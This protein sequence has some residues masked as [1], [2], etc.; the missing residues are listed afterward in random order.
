MKKIKGSIILFLILIIC[1]IPGIVVAD[2]KDYFDEDYWEWHTRTTTSDLAYTGKHIEI[3]DNKIEFFGY[4]TTSYKDFL[5]KE[6]D[7]AGSKTFK[8]QLELDETKADYHTLDGAGFI[9]N[10]KKN[11]GKLTGDIL[12]VN[13]EEIV[14]YRIE[15]IDIEEFETTPNKILADYKKDSNSTNILESVAK[16]ETSIHKFTIKTTPEN[17]TVIDNEK[18]VLNYNLDYSKHVGNDFGLIVSYKQHS[19][20]KLTKIEFSEFELEIKDYNIMIKNTDKKE[21]PIEKSKFQILDS[22]GNVLKTMT[23][24]DNGEI[25]L[26]GVSSGDYILKQVDVNDE[27][28]LNKEEIKFSVTSDGKVLDPKTKEEIDLHVIN[29]KNE[30]IDNNKNDKV[31]NNYK[32]NIK[33]EEQNKNKDEKENLP[34]KLPDAG[35]KIIIGLIILCILS[36]L[37]QYKGYNMRI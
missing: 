9:F 12:V 20:G 34:N 18:E 6:Y 3:N 2:T 11:N 10:A 22:D 13:K 32:E 37:I 25:Y 17:I 29:E 30:V 21:N 27:Y 33:K 26:R 14:L 8:V 19:C 15:N 35:K 7:F 23:T 31:G 16:P 1:L 5:Y 36:I 28:I 24:D 4:G